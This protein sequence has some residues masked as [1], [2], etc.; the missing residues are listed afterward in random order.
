MHCRRLEEKTNSL[1]ILILETHFIC[2]DELGQTFVFRLVMRL[3]HKNGHKTQYPSRR[4][5]TIFHCT[6]FKTHNGRQCVTSI[7]RQVMR[8]QH[9][10]G[11][12]SKRQQ[13]VL[14]SHENCSTIAVNYPFCVLFSWKFTQICYLFDFHLLLQRKWRDVIQK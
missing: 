3:Q 9:K 12:S 13:S 5:S 1:D 14:F 7:K 10:H 8:H 2:L 11:H 6:S 4:T